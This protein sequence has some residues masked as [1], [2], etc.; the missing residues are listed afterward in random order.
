MFW[1]I[2]LT[3]T[4]SEDP[5]YQLHATWPS[6]SDVAFIDVGYNGWGGAIYFSNEEFNAEIMS[7]TFFSCWAQIG[8]AIYNRNQDYGNDHST[9]VVKIHKCCANACFCTG[10]DDPIGSFGVTIASNDLQQISVIECYHKNNISCI[11]FETKSQTQQYKQNNMSNNKS[12]TCICNI[13]NPQNEIQWNVF[14]GNILSDDGHVVLFTEKTQTVSNCNFYG[15]Q[16]VAVRIQIDTIFNNCYFINNLFDIK[17][18]RSYSSKFS[19][20]NCSFSNIQ[21]SGSTSLISNVIEHGEGFPPQM[22]SY[23]V[24][25]TY[26]PKSE[27]P[28]PPFHTPKQ[29]PDTTIEI[30]P[31][32][33]PFRTIP[34]DCIIIE[35]PIKPRKRIRVVF[36]LLEF[37]F[38]EMI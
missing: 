12:G 4:G 8:A 15:N 25:N 7:C 11:T 19:L 27:Y 34:D 33:T 30:T 9:S 37:G 2:F 17:V 24:D 14:D 16:G 31:G 29:T 21:V 6:I 28:D 3:L 38:N 36:S 10:S 13:F 22:I 18:Y 26:C 5:H 20:I 32:V 23:M 35:E 1:C